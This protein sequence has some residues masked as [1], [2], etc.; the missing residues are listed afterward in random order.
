MSFLIVGVGCSGKTDDH[1]IVSNGVLSFRKDL[2]YGSVGT[3]GSQGFYVA[4]R[5]IIFRNEEWTPPG[6]PTS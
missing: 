3:H 1:E 6:G 4:S 2:K 5:H